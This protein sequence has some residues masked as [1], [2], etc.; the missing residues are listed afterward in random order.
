M[1]GGEGVQVPGSQQPRH[2]AGQADQGEEDVEDGGAAGEA[3]GGAGEHEHPLPHTVDGPHHHQEGVETPVQP[4]L[5][6]LQGEGEGAGPAELD[7]PVEE[8]CQEAVQEEL[9]Q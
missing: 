2:Q 6:A 8:N 7:Q 4:Q 5:P 9:G 3:A 1:A